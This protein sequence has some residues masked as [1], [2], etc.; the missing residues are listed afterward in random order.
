MTMAIIPIRN[1]GAL[2][3]RR[4]YGERRPPAMIL[5]DKLNF[6]RV[7]IPLRYDS[8]TKSVIMQ[9]VLSVVFYCDFYPGS[10]GDTSGSGTLLEPW[11][12]FDHAI[13]M[14]NEIISCLPLD[15]EKCC[16]YITLKCTGVLDKTGSSSKSFRYNLIID[17]LIWQPSRNDV[18]S[19][20][21]VYGGYRKFLFNSIIYNA[22]ITTHSYYNC[23][24]NYNSRTMA[25]VN[26][27]SSGY[28][29]NCKIY[30]DCEW[31]SGYRF[32]L[33]NVSEGSICNTEINCILRFHGRFNDGRT[34]YALNMANSV[35]EDCEI[36]CQYTHNDTSGG[37]YGL[38]ITVTGVV[39]S[40]SIIKSCYSEAIAAYTI[41]GIGASCAYA[42]GCAYSGTNNTY[43]NCTKEESGLIYQGNC[44]PAITKQ[45]CVTI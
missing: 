45:Q 43:Y 30:I 24:F 35:L 20:I 37:F 44:D 41:A 28:I 17:G 10:S 9:S 7:S 15:Y 12:D 26:A 21:I 5:Q 18:A 42:L 19:Q 4:V 31:S 38:G 2:I 11:H 6:E 34:V 1:N 33:C 23:I 25:G 3:G 40:N 8:L 39:A 29:Y 27:T 14:M 13:D 16:I 36:L 22:G 32:S